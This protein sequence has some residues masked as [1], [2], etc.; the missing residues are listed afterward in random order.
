VI[1]ALGGR[2]ELDAE[3]AQAVTALMGGA[4]RVRL[5]PTVPERRQL[6]RF[7]AGGPGVDAAARIR[8]RSSTCANSITSFAHGCSSAEWHL[9]DVEYR[10]GA[11]GSTA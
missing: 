8:N 4:A 3:D 11:A 5:Q 1:Q 10:A 2:Q 6:G 9:A 7:S